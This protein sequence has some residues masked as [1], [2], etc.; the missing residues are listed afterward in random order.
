MRQNKQWRLVLLVFL[1]LLWPATTAFADTSSSTNYQ[2]NQTFF[3]SG[4][5][6]D[7]TSASYEAKQ[8]A[9]ELGIGNTQGT[10][11]QAYA[12]FNTTDDPFI[13]FVVPETSIDLGYLDDTAATTTTATFYVRAWQSGGYVVITQSDPPA[14]TGNG[15]LL[16]AMTAG[17]ASSPGTE[18]FGIN[19]VDN[20]SPDVGADP[21]QVPDATFSNGQ[22]YTGYDTPDDFRYNK[23]D[24]IAS[25][26][27]STSVTIFTISYLYN[28]STITPDGQY[29]FNHNIVATATY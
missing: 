21:Q 19:L 29:D 11:Y 16:S 20:T 7:A 4:G 12:G 24:I 14:N 10:A 22:P 27:Q 6:L 3:G 18:Q 2:V 17:G 26:N 25:T 5:E 28:I 23:G 1:T 15:Y 9:G 8:T 13:E